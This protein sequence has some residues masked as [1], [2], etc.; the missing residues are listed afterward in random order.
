MQI[1]WILIL[2]AIQ[3]TKF[4]EASDF[5]SPLLLVNTTYGL[6]RGI[7]N[8]VGIRQWKG[9]PYAAPPIGSLRWEYPV[10]PANYNLQNQIY[11]ANF[12][13]PGMN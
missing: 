4:I 6:V 1:A 2:F 9:I 8:E 7:I 13:A 10:P 5:S 12:D 11:E 3:Q